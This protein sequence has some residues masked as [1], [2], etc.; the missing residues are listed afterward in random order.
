MEIDVYVWRFGSGIFFS[1]IIGIFSVLYDLL[2]LGN[3]LKKVYNSL[4]FFF[5]MERC[6]YFLFIMVDNDEIFGSWRSMED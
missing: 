6:L 2:K 4:K 3:L 1:K 5:F